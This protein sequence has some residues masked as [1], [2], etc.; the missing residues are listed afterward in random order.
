[1]FRVVVG[2]FFCLCVIRLG[3]TARRSS[4]DRRLCDHHSSPS[5]GA[6]MAPLGLF[7]PTCPATMAMAGHLQDAAIE[8]RSLPTK[9]ISTAVFNIVVDAALTGAL[10]Q[11]ERLVMFK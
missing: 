1:M 6:S 5:M 11:C 2:Y 9:T 3:F 7:V 10:E 8:S 4:V